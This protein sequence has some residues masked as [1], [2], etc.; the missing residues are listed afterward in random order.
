MNSTLSRSLKPV[1]AR[2]PHYLQQPPAVVHGH[3]P[4]YR[5]PERPPPAAV[6][7]VGN[8]Q[9]PLERNQLRSDPPSQAGQQQLLGLRITLVGP[10]PPPAGGMATQTRQ[11]AELLRG[12]QAEVLVVPTNTPYRPSWAGKVVGLRAICRLMPYLVALWRAA[13]SS[14]LFHVM[15]NSGWSWHL[16]AAPAIWVGWLRGVPVVVNYRG[17]EAASFLDRS[18]R[19]VRWSMRR[20]KSLAVPS[21]FLEKVFGQFGMRA[22][23]VPNIIDLSRF[24][25]AVEHAPNPTPH[26]IVTRNLEPIYDV[27]TALRAFA[28]LRQSHTGARLTIAGS[29]PQEQRLLQLSQQLDVAASVHFAGRLD[30]DQIA[31]LYREADIMLNSSVADNMPN[32]ILESLASGVPVVSTNVGGIP[33]LVEDGKTALLVAPRDPQ[34]LAHAAELLLDDPVLRHRLSSAGVEEAQ[35]YTWERVRPVL[36]AVYRKALAEG[37][38]PGSASR[39]EFR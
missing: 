22:E 18:Q 9:T 13:A 32:S 34:A 17:G 7:Q 2:A 29:G 8:S 23:V 21:R 38:G 27:E 5:S 28:L 30:R 15:A 35:R 33:F 3:H 11:L 24:F 31:G 16:F 37:S 12:E 26:L 20:A 39:T 36:T 10:V 4:E 25:E 19:L 14:D 1:T 6:G